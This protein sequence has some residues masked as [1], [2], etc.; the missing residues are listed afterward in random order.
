MTYQ[1][2]YNDGYADGNADG[3]G[4]GW[5]E[6]Y[7]FADNQDAVASSI[8]IGIIDVALLP[9]NFFLACLNFEVFG[10]NIGSM[11]TALLTVMI[12][13]IIVRVVFGGGNKN[14]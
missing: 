10:I 12:V 7:R 13:I 6:G 3:Y 8:F 5:N 1:D 14:G 2:G 4:E 9:I 11:V